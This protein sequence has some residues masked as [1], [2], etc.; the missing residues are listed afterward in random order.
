MGGVVPYPVT[1]PE[2]ESE[3]LRGRTPNLSNT[4]YASP[5]LPILDMC[6]S[7]HTTESLIVVVVGWTGEGHCTGACTTD[8]VSRDP[9]TRTRVEPRRP[10]DGLW[11]DSFQERRLGRVNQTL[12]TEVEI[13]NQTTSPPLDPDQGLPRSYQNFPMET[14]ET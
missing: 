3:V 7:P 6:L 10:T 14:P 9:R 1:G 11:E 8:E 5:S 12:R 13:D 4:L 2:S